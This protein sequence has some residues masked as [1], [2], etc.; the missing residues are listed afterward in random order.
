MQRTELSIKSYRTMKTKDMFSPWPLSLMSKRILEI[1][2]SLNLAPLN[3]S[4]S[5]IRFKS[6]HTRSD[7]FSEGVG[8]LCVWVFCLSGCL[9]TTCT[10]GTHWGQKRGPGTGVTGSCE[11]PWEGWKLNLPL[12]AQSVL[13]TAEGAIFPHPRNVLL[14]IFLVPQHSVKQM[15][16]KWLRKRQEVRKY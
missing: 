14:I 13:L 1:Y 4:L 11:L 10:P 2:H 12:E 3:F 6:P 16:L 9:Y 15:C 7:G 5:P 8:I